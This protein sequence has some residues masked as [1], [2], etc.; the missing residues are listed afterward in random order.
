MTSHITV[1]NSVK[2]MKICEC[3]MCEHLLVAILIQLSCHVIKSL[4]IVF[5]CNEL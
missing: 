4:S 3:I 5:V 2:T 1:R